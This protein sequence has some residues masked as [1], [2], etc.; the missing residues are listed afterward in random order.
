MIPGTPRPGTRD[1]YLSTVETTTFEQDR[2]A[3]TAAAAARDRIAGGLPPAADAALARA[4]GVA[5][6]VAHYDP[7]PVAIEGVVLYTL[8]AAGVVTDERAATLASPDALEFARALGRLGRFDVS[9]QWNV[10]ASGPT[11]LSGAQAE[12]LRKMLLAVVADPRLVLARVA[13]QLWLLRNAKQ[14]PEPERRRLALQTREVYGP[15]AN[16]LGLAHLKWELEDHT[17]RYLQ[18]EDYRRIA[19]SLNEKRADRERYIEDVRAQLADELGRAGVRAES[20]AGRSTSTAS[21]GRCSAST[22][23]SSRCSTCAR[24][25]S[26]SRT[27]P[28]CYARSASCTG[29]GSTSRASSTTTSRRRRPNGY[30]SIHTAVLGPGGRRARGPDPHARDARARGAR[31]RRALALQGGR[32]AR[33]RLRAQARAA[34]RTAAAGRRPTPTRTACS[35]G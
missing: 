2:A 27:S 24:S 17:F 22:S 6:I 9:A 34:A 4:E 16:R 32:Q 8:V 23:R 26:W 7:D 25:A 10:A 14:L 3:A 18:P 35:T 33:R 28:Q 5:Q 15:L 19:S 20:R 30:R 21:G 13:E 12:A 31:R 1:A 11:V 29:C